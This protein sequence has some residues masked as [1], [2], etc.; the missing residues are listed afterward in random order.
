MSGNTLTIA[1]SDIRRNAWVWSSAALVSITV[2][3]FIAWCLGFMVAVASTPESY[4][5]STNGGQADYL[6][7]GF[8]MLAFS[9]LPAVIILAIVISGITSHTAISQSLWSLGGASPNQMT[10]MILIQAVAVCCTSVLGGVALA[11]PFQEAINNALI[12][13]GNSDAAPLPTV[14]SPWTL[15]GTIVILTILTVVAAIVP[16]RRAALQSPITLR[17]APEQVTRPGIGTLIMVAVVFLAIVLPLLPSLFGVFMVDDPALA[18]VATLPLSQALVLMTA[19]LSPFLLPSVI[20]AWTRPF[21]TSSSTSWRIARH[22]AVARVAGMAG[23]IAPLTLGIGLFGTFGMITVTTANASHVGTSINT[24]EG[25]ILILPASVISGLGS[26]AA[27]MMAARQHTEDIVTLRSA[28]GTPLGTDRILLLEAVII[29]VSAALIAMLPIS[30]E[31]GFLVFALRTHG[32][33]VDD[34]GI[35][36]MPVSLFI[37]LAFVCISCALLMTARAAWRKPLVDLLADR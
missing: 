23:T 7:L 30:I 8:N 27:V 25:L 20:S 21:V 16:A 15:L 36:L 5:W 2:S 1:L 34:I 29:T 37:V 9:G 19:V 10:R 22:F 6:N 13:V 11:L 26:I 35:D 33:G 3:V 18:V 4:Q 24:V 12:R 32:R 31:F 14:H 28:T 17:S